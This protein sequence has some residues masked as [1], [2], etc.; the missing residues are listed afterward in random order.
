MLKLITGEVDNLI[1]HRDEC[2]RTKDFS[3][4]KSDEKMP[5]LTDKEEHVILSEMPLDK[6]II[7][8]LSIIEQL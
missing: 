2:L 6:T 5:Y 7:V 3:P 4:Y 1:K 8:T